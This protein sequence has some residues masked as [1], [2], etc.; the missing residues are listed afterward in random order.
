MKDVTFRAETPPRKVVVGTLMKSFWHPYE[1]LTKRLDDLAGCIDMMAIR[2]AEAGFDG[3][4]DLVVLPENAVCDENAKHASERSIAFDG[5]VREVF[6]ESARKHN[7]YIVVPLFLDEGGSFSNAAVLVDRTGE[8][9]GIYRKAH[10]VLARGAATYEGGVIAGSDYPV[11][12]CDFGR[13]GIQICFDI[14]FDDG[15]QALSDKGAEIVAWPTQSPQTILPAARAL[16]GC[17]YLI[18]STWRN[19]TS[20]FEPHGDLAA[21]TESD[22]ILV[23]QIDL[24]YAILRWQPAL[25]HGE[26]FAR[27]YGDRVGHHYSQREDVGLF[28]SNDPGKSIGQMVRERE[29][30]H[31][32]ELFRR[33]QQ[34]LSSAQ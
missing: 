11:F 21:Q 14:H 8:V 15:W 30:E 10:P 23:H 17:Y 13:L 24:S 20:I 5:P 31:E 22:P 29:M 25:Q 1:G 9:A 32:T 12:E 3:K 19:N 34:G 33:Y 2:S 18:S 4:L 26:L 16:N 7:T 27:H 6:R 28:W